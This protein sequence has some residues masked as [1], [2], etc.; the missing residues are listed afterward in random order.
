M[1]RRT[2]TWKWGILT[3]KKFEC[4]S[5]TYLF[6]VLPYHWPNALEGRA[7]AHKHGV[8]VI[9]LLSDFSTSPV[10]ST[11]SRR[12]MASC[13]PVGK[14][15]YSMMVSLCCA[16]FT[17]VEDHTLYAGTTQKSS[18]NN[19]STVQV[20]FSTERG[21]GKMPHSASFLSDSRT[22]L[23]CILQSSSENSPE[24]EFHL[25]TL[26]TQSGKLY[27]LTVPLFK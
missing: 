6:P 9:T 10:D 5:M 11:K 16:H 1:S 8:G 7:V 23:K 27:V 14:K 13:C 2:F 18:G 12:S 15:S 20:W 17:A 22:S 24:D 4:G 21:H 3:Y 26:E 19:T 25:P